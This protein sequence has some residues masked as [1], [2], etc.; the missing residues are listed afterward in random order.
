M[1]LSSVEQK[2]VEEILT[3]IEA[4]DN[5]LDSEFRVLKAK[6]F[7]EKL[8]LFKKRDELLQKIPNFWL[9]CLNNSPI[10]T[11]FNDE[12]LNVLQYITALTAE[13]ANNF[14]KITLSFGENDLIENKTLS[15]TVYAG[16]NGKVVADTVKWKKAPKRSKT[17]TD[18]AFFK[19]FGEE[20]TE[21][22]N[23]IVDVYESPIEY[24]EADNDTE[25]TK[26]NQTL[27]DNE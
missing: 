13:V 1:T 21:I 23:D 9:A 22:T 25:D 8:P 10:N 17:E 12:D 2:S 14:D 5:K 26:S 7:K 18:C 24:Y 19:I 6:Y 20:E 4:L 16:E 11:H 15:K 3:K 27:S